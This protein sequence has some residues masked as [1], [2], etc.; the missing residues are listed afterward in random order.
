MC[1]TNCAPETLCTSGNPE[2]PKL[3]TK[4]DVYSYGVMACEPVVGQLPYPEKFQDMPE[5]VKN[6]WEIMH[7]I[8]VRCTK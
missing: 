3:T 4:V 7:G 5:E 8:I 2:S 6:E 1:N